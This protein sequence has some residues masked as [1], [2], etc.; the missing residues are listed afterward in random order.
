M[1]RPLLNSQSNTRA[2]EGLS[3]LPVAAAGPK[4]GEDKPAPPTRRSWGQAAAGILR[5]GWQWLCAQD[6]SLIADVL[7]A[8]S[9][10]VLLYAFLAAPL[11]AGWQ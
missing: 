1:A 5:A 6:D 7:G 3:S 9:L 4:R 10:F 8:V 2:G 11:I